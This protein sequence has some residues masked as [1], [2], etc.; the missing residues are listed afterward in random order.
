MRRVIKSIKFGIL[1]SLPLVFIGC[2]KSGVLLRCDSA[3][4]KGT[5]VREITEFLIDGGSV[6]LDSG[7]QLISGQM[8]SL[9]T[10][11][12]ETERLAT[13]RV[14]V[15]RLVDSGK[16]TTTGF[17]ETEDET[18][19]NPLQG[20]P[21]LGKLS[22]GKWVYSLESGTATSKQLKKLKSMSDEIT[23]TLYPSHRVRIGDRWDIDPQAVKVF[24]GE[25]VLRFSGTGS[26]ALNSLTQ[27]A[28]HECAQLT[29]ILQATATWLDDENNEVTV[30]L[31]VQTEILR[32]IDTFTDLSQN[33][34]GYIKMSGDILS[35]GSR[36]K[37]SL[38][39]PVKISSFTIVK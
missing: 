35:N 15:L 36:I 5:V 33:G 19:T 37:M 23:E 24:L 2:G 22:N 1:L 11:A 8:T 21:V 14:R 39:G 38:T 20:I 7:G 26:M 34:K 16:T 32:A 4:K 10:T 12:V 30:D 9:N 13:D 25:D 17:G 6:T 31:G 27:Y 3:L 18:T 29:L 28:G